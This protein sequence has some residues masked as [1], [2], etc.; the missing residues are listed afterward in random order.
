ML[1]QNNFLIAELLYPDAEC[2]PEDGLSPY[3][4]TRPLASVL[5]REFAIPTILHI[6]PMTPKA[7]KIP[8]A[9]TRGRDGAKIGLLRR[10]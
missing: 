6:G 1:I 9:S 5:W 7:C 2:P 8:T 3:G 4:R 10:I